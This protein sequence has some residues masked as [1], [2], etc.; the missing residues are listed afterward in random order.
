MYGGSVI[1]VKVLPRSISRLSLVSVLFTRVKLRACTCTQ[2]LR[3][4]GN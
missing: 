3:D 1:G 2:K 4:D